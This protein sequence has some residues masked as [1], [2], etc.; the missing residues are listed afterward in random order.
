VLDVDD[1]EDGAVRVLAEDLVDLDVV[2]PEGVARRVP[3]HELLLLADLH[4]VG[5]TLR[6]MSNIASWKRWSRNQILDWLG[7]S[8]NGIA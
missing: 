1:E 6:I 4:R 5:R 2:G 7:S 3:P 8:S